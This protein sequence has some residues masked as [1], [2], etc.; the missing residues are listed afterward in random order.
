M[1]ELTDAQKNKFEE[2][3]PKLN[4]G[5]IHKQIRSQLQNPVF[6]DD[7]FHGYVL[8]L[9]KSESG[10][11]EGNVDKNGNPVFHVKGQ[12]VTIDIGGPAAKFT[13]KPSSE[14]ERLREENALLKDENSRAK[15]FA[16]QLKEMK[17]TLTGN[18]REVLKWRKNH[19]ISDSK[20]LSKLM[21]TAKKKKL[22]KENKSDY[23]PPSFGM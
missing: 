1:T 14:L 22:E 20:D 16:Q 12:E 10:E 6:A 18:L 9:S 23:E 2:L 3:Y 7:A 21:N 4:G 13:P 8:Q 19:G 15:T 17:A 11:W 5:G